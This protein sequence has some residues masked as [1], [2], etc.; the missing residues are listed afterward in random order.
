MINKVYPNLKI[1]KSFLDKEI[2]CGIDEVGRGC[3]AG[4][5]IAAAVILD[6]KNIPKG[7]NDSKK[8]SKKMREIISNEIK[9]TSIEV[10]IGEASVYEIDKLNILNAS[11]LAM[12][13]AYYNLPKKPNVALIDGNFSPDI[14]CK[15]LNII[16]GDTKSLSIAAASI[17][18]KVHKDKIFQLLH[19]KFPKYNFKNNSGYG[20][21]EHYTAI[22]EFGICQ[23]HRKSFKLYK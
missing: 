15:V 12:K 2:V 13:R 19:K 16:K 22:S 20:T 18:A 1:E 10:A 21:K 6:Y 11:I 5:V 8:L 7:I 4:P 23:H 14:N 17:I 9:K 3:L